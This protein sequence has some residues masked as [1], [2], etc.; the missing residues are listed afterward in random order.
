MP[1]NINLEEVLH[2]TGLSSF[3]WKDWTLVAGLSLSWL[4]I[5]FGVGYPLESLSLLKEYKEKYNKNEI[6]KKPTFWNVHS[7]DKKYKILNSQN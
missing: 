1:I 6:E 5:Y 3:T 2:A 7:I 4:P